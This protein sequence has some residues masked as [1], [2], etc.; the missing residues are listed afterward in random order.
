[1]AWTEITR[2]KYRR[3]GLRYG[4]GRIELCCCVARAGASARRRATLSMA[5]SHLKSGGMPT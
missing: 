4:Y 5:A 3:D 1:M 2:R